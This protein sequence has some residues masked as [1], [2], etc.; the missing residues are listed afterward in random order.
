MR[1]SV[2]WMIITIITPEFTLG[3]A[4][5]RLGSALESRKNFRDLAATDGIEW[6]LKHGF[7]ANM[8][9]FA[10]EVKIPPQ[11]TQPSETW[12]NGSVRGQGKHSLA[13]PTAFK[14]VSVV[15]TRSPESTSSALANA[16]GIELSNTGGRVLL[17]DN[18]P[19]TTSGE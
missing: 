6:T 9:G 13:K 7:Y 1:K 18:A 2:K 8:G 10:I 11:K 14:C 5:A 19:Q 3:I 16:D 12:G 4:A 17:Q 15:P